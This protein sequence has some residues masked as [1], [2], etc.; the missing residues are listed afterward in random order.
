MLVST[1]SD[2][3]YLGCQLTLHFYN[4]RVNFSWHVTGL[5]TSARYLLNGAASA[6]ALSYYKSCIQPLITLLNS[7]VYK[8]LQIMDSKDLIIGEQIIHSKMHLVCINIWTFRLPICI[9]LCIILEKEIQ[10]IHG[11]MHLL[12]IVLPL[13]KCCIQYPC[14]DVPPSAGDRTTCGSSR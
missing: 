9:L 12:C 1:T 7:S 13:P 14:P 5:H 6:S 2:A 11:K 3:N 10:I 4:P 8:L